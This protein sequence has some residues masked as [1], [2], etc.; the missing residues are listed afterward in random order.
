MIIPSFTTVETHLVLSFSEPCS[1]K[2]SSTL[3]EGHLSVHLVLDQLG[4]SHGTAAGP[5]CSSL[6]AYTRRSTAT[7]HMNMELSND[8]L[9]PCI[10]SRTESTISPQSYSSDLHRCSTFDPIGDILRYT[11]QAILIYPPQSVVISSML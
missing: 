2:L 10:P 6:H 4:F 1:R 11:C 3:T 5:P 8:S 7:F 9:P